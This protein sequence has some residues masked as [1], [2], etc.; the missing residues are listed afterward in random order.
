MR[1]LIVFAGG[2]ALCAA[3]VAT[4]HEEKPQ[5]EHQATTMQPSDRSVSLDR[6]ICVKQDPFTGS[7][8]AK[9]TCHSYRDWLKQGIDPL[10]R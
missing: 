10:D 6:T 4:A 3:T 8:I 9:K 7:R 2:L 1:T 5:T